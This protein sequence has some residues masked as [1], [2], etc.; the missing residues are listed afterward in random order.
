M[1]ELLTT[2]ELAERLRVRPRTVQEWTKRQIIPAIRFSHKVVRY[3]FGEVVGALRKRQ[4]VDH[5]K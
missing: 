4:G 3:D 1:I 5:A 2:A